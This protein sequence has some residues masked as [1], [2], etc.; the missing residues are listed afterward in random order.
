MKYAAALLAAIG[1]AGMSPSAQGA[2]PAAAPA[3]RPRLVVLISVDQ[4]RGDY[5]DRFRHQWTKGL[6]RLVTEGAW[7]RQADYPYYTTVTCA[8]HASI[9]T[10]TVPAVH[11]MAANSWADRNNSRTVS[12]TDDETQK[13]ISYGGPVTGVGHSAATLMSPTLSDELRSQGWPVPKVVGISLKARSAITLAGHKPDA[14]IWLD[15]RDGEWVTSTAFAK[16]PVPF[17]ADYIAKHPVRAEL[18]RT[19]NRALPKEQY[20]YAESTA[21]RRRTPHVTTGFPHTIKGRG[22]EVGGAIS[23][24]WEAS[25]FSDAYLAALASL[26]IDELKLGR[27]TATDFLA[28]S[29]SALDLTGHSYGPDSHEVQD[30]LVQLD[31][32]IGLLLDKLDRDIGKGM[33]VVGLSSDHG[34]A[35]VPERMTALGF[36][37]G[38]IDAPAIGRAI[39]AVLARMLGPAQYRTRVLANDIFFND[40]VYLKLT[41]NPA[42]MEAVLDTV[43]KVEGVFRVYRKEQLSPTDPLTR[44]SFLSHYE[45]RSG[46]IK[47]L[48]RAYWSLSSSTSTHGTG[49]RYDTRVPVMLFGY[50][51]K[52]GEYL[53][54]VAPIDLAPTLA[55]LTGV[56]LPDAMGRV[57]TEA[58][59]HH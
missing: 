5:V 9:S 55:F 3:D 37:A 42:A 4:M 54:P 31:A 44:P 6:H 46:D 57:L 45:G 21:G 47:M 19:W 34:V 43:R 28:V 11:G 13:L 15:E 48:G 25:P 17:L 40:G 49:H 14:V 18:G 1:L 24:A 12:C 8:G 20:L 36:D 38:R 52:K 39:D 7:F 30:V 32:Q 23:D 2:R 41:Q 58:L 59:T 56:T 10:G 50:G 51:I 27:G 33:Y 16:A 26:S 53:E 29:F 35:P 22:D